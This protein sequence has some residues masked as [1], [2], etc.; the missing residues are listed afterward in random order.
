MKIYQDKEKKKR[1]RKKEKTIKSLEG[2]LLEMEDPHNKKQYE[3][4]MQVLWSFL[5]KITEIT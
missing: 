1:E 2:F 3:D 5:T 4:N